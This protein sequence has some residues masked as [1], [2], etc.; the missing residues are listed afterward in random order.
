MYICERRCIYPDVSGTRFSFKL[1]AAGEAYK[2][3][4]YD[5]SGRKIQAIHGIASGD[6]EAV[7]WDLTNKQG[8]RVSAGVYLY[9]FESTEIKTIGKVVV[10]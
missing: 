1:P 10:R 9:R 7:N 4:L 6:E 3:C 5:V 2:I 8:A